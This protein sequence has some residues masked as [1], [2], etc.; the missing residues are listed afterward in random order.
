[1][2]AL[3]ESA[4]IE[5]TDAYGEVSYENLMKIIEPKAEAANSGEQGNNTADPVESE[6]APAEQN[7]D[8]SNSSDPEKEGT[9]A[10]AQ[11]PAE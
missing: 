7:S 5:H 8:E 6:S 3:V 11:Q 10:P 9:E 2:T 1:M 4:K